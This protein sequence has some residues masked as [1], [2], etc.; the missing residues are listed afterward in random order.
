MLEAS[1]VLIAVADTFVDEADVVEPAVIDEWADKLNAS[2]ETDD[3][4]DV[5]ETCCDIKEH[6]GDDLKKF[7][8]CYGEDCQLTRELG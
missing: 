3:A 5:Y 8:D 1:D 2:V 7:V 6:L 4:I